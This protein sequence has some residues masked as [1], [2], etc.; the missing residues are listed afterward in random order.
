MRSGVGG[1]WRPAQPVAGAAAGAPAGGCGEAGAAEVE[2]GPGGAE[3]GRSLPA[4]GT[5]GRSFDREAG[6][7]DARYDGLH[8]VLTGLEEPVEWVRARCS[9]SWEI[10]HGCRVL[11]HPP[12]GRPGFHRAERRVRAHLA[13]CCLAFAL[14]R[15]LRHR[16]RPAPP[17]RPVPSEERRLE[18]LGEVQ[19]SPG[20]DPGSKRD[21][22]PAGPITAEQRRL[23]A[24][25][26]LKPPGRTVPAPRS[27]RRR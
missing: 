3:P 21:F 20:H 15:L 12:A 19:S 27:R 8:G 4:S 7:R 23:Y 14:L 10:E 17:G 26:G 2:G 13:I 9:Q 18:E 24:A 5:G 11:E 22:A 6:K 1:R 25:V 16:Y